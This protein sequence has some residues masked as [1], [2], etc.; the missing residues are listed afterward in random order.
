MIGLTKSGEYWDPDF[1]TA[2][3]KDF[4]PSEIIA[5]DLPGSGEFLNQKS[6]TSIDGIV[7]TTRKNYENFFKNKTE[8]Y[9]LISVSLGGMVATS[10]LEKYESDFDDFVIINSSFKNLSS[11][12]KRVQPMAMLKFFKVAFT[13]DIYKKERS[14][15]SMTSN[16]NSRKDKTHIRWA[17]ISQ[18]KNMSLMN[19]IRQTWAGFKYRLTYKPNIPSLIIASRH[20]KLAHYTCSENLH[21]FWN[22]DY[23]LYQDEIIGHGIHLDAPFRL[24]E[25][26]KSWYKK[27]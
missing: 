17:S 18:K 6:P 3:Q 8:K 12:T 24:S 26:I 9:L 5:F 7:E 25:T 21:K 20:D 4:N 10:W 14:V 23:F 13:N 19:M 11:L 22:K 2:L 27:D 1:V 16:N 15:V